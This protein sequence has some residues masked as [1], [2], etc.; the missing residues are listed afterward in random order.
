GRPLKESR[1]FE[2]LLQIH[3]IIHEVRYK[4]RVRHGLI[5]APHDAERDVLVV[6]L[7]ETRDDGVIRPLASCE[8][9][10]MIRLECKTGT[11]TLQWE[12]SY[13]HARAESAI[14]ALDPAR[15]IAM[16]IDHREVN[17][18]A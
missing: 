6:S 12:S 1:R 14:D 10:G 15:H 11:A 3:S 5:R 16:T 4:L 13:R 7:H 18:F 2:C 8:D 17:R 9:V